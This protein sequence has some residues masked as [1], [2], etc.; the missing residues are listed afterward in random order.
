MRSTSVWRSLAM[1]SSWRWRECS[2]SPRSAMGM[3]VAGWDQA[4]TR[5]QLTALLFA[6]LTDCAMP[7]VWAQCCGHGRKRAAASGSPYSLQSPGQLR[8]ATAQA[9]D[10]AL[11]RRFGRGRSRSGHERAIA[12][13]RELSCVL[14]IS[15]R[16]S[17]VSTFPRV[18]GCRVEDWTWEARR[19]RSSVPRWGAHPCML[20]ARSAMVPRR[21]AASLGVLRDD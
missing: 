3:A 17:R 21:R 6:A 18:P 7:H 4:G 2:S 14:A 9:H 19:V 5:R 1:I 16:R 10:T 12:Y 20:G 15:G 11:A 8:S 13:H